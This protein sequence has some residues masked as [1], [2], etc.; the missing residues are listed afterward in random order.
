[1]LIDLHCHTGAYSSCSSLTPETLV[2]AAREAGLDG[3]C[4]TEH[5]RLWPADQLRRLG[6]A[7]GI[8]V[9]R[10]M[11]VTTELGH[12]LVY[13]L[14]AP[15]SGMWSAAGLCA[16]VRAAGGIA[17]LAHPARAGQPFV[18]PAHRRR[19]FDTVET[20]N[21]SDGPEQNTAA[22]GLLSGMPLPGI[23]GSDCHAPHEVGTAVTELPVRVRTEHDLVTA[24]RLGRHRT[25]H[26]RPGR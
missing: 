5:D 18:P 20:L 16:A 3:V 14:D 21:G 24:L 22:L 7:Y 25:R 4:L 8:V 19:L 2:A 9:L 26:H 1:M 17:V 23:A 6:E 11:E 13:G 15:P 12:V 10:G